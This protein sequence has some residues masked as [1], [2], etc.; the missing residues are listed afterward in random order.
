[1]S[2]ITTSGGTKKRGNHDFIKVMAGKKN[3]RTEVA[4]SSLYFPRPIKEVN[5]NIIANND[6]G[7]AT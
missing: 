5:T 1:L 4:E 6:A 3:S 2:G 7:N